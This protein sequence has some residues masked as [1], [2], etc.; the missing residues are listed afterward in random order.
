[1]A[2]LSCVA[3]HKL[4]V[5]RRGTLRQSSE[6]GTDLSK[7]TAKD[8]FSRRTYH[9]NPCAASATERLVKAFYKTSIKRI[10]EKLLRDRAESE[11][12]RRNWKTKTK[13]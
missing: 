9:S 13:M 5:R 7:E 12:D 4:L 11:L 8:R 3:S 1:M 10:A 6:V 2:L